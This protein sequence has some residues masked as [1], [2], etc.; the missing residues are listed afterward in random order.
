MGQKEQVSIIM[1][2]YNSGVYLEATLLSI[3]SQT[4]RNWELLITD[5]CSSDNTV[6]IIE[7]YMLEDDR[8]KLYRL[9]ANSGPAVARNLSIDKAKGR[10]IAFCDS[11]DIWLESKLEE[12]IC[13]M[14]SNSYSFTYTNLQYCNFQ[15]E[16]RG[17]RNCPK[18]I[19]Y[20]KLLISCGMVC[21]SVV[22]DAS[23]L[24]K[25]YM[26]LIRKRQDWA[27]WLQ[28]IRRAEKAYCLNRYLLIYRMVPNSV[29]SK[30]LQLIKYNWAVYRDVEH[31]SVC[32]SLCLFV[33]AYTPFYF[34]SKVKKCFY[35][36]FNI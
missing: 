12:Q 2:T 20:R 9:K 26:P 33:F 11:D 21:S 5:D 31:L 3:I 35:R 25:F 17:H 34:Y 28:I 1:P 8:I 36:L 19:T 32:T 14:N 24:G 30:K 29:S 4:Y 18:R 13:F 16:I 7:R 27:L 10:Y 15:G 22:Y 23:I 6:S